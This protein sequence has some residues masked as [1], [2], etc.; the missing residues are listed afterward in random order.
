M[1]KVGTVFSGIGSIEHAL[2]RLNVPFD[3]KFAC[4]NGDV[5][6]LSESID[7]SVSAIEEEFEILMKI[8][9]NI[10]DKELLIF[11]LE[12]TRINFEDVLK[13]LKVDENQTT[14]ILSI[15]DKYENSQDI[16]SNQQKA[17]KTIKNRL[18]TLEK[19]MDISY[20]LMKLSIKLD[21]DIKRAIGVEKKKED[22][23]YPVF[24]SNTTFKKTVKSIK[25]VR[26][27]LS[28][29]HERVNTEAI[30]E[31]VFSLE[32]LKDQKDLID[33]L[34][35]KHE[36][37][38]RVKQSYMANY[39]IAPDNFHWNVSFLDGTHFKNEI[40]LFVGGSPCQSFS[41]VGKQRG[42]ADTRG[43]LFYEF[44]RLVGEIKPKVFIYEN[45]KAVLTNDGG[46]TWETMTTLFDQLGYNWSFKVMN[47]KDYGVPQN[48]ER[49]FVV[50]FRKD[51]DVNEFEFPGT[52]ELKST[53][54]DFLLDK[55]SGKYYLPEK[56]VKFVTSEKNIQKR[57]TQIDGDIQLCQKRNQQFNW[58]G[59]FV[60][61]EENKEKE[62]LMEDLEKY[63]LSEKV[64]KYVLSSGTKG[65]YSRPEIDLEIARPLLTTMHKMHRAGVD[66][67]VTT[68]GRIRKLTPRECLRLMGF[69]DSFKIVVSDTSAY[70]QSGNSIVVDVLMNILDSIFIS[71]PSLLGDEINEC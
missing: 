55:V 21:A 5:D 51:L 52:I 63:F 11:D 6:I 70:Q 66:N 33:K 43:T 36:K 14:E 58:H 2:E 62:E 68:E 8:A 28:M 25:L 60:F 22:Y 30:R 34:Y 47:A 49:V 3:I 12:K 57:Y 19:K 10:E 13:D 17:Y 23:N 41:L 4:D 27:D 16:N 56:G 64:K 45:V 42:L 50:G 7:D 48:R 1:L 38:N 35:E 69:C 44:A 40:D 9:D 24:K 54:Q 65:F 37:R 32:T 71:Y 20:E 61:E 18:S 15:L 59:D 67:Y 53:M 46:N 31:K 29:F 39:N 26:D